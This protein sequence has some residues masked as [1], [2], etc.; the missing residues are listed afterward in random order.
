MK[1]IEQ[2]QQDKEKLQSKIDYLKMI[3]NHEV[4]ESVELTIKTFGYDSAGKQYHTDRYINQHDIP[5]K[6]NLELSILL[7]DSIEFLQEQIEV[8]NFDINNSDDQT[9]MDNNR[10]N[11]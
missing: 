11:L 4:I 8:L 1:K 3:V 2:L 10:G 9:T 7:R 5:F 6:L